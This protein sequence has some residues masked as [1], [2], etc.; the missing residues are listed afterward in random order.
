MR[1]RMTEA[2]LRPR[3]IVRLIALIAVFAI[4]LGAICGIFVLDARRAAWNQA[5]ESGKS[6]VA[7]IESD[8]SRTIAS[9]DLSLQAVVDNL[10]HPEI[11]QLSP[12]LRQLL[13]FDRSATAPHLDAIALLDENGIVRFESRTTHSKPLSRAERDYFQFHRSNDSRDL[14]ISQPFTARSNGTPLVAVSRRVSH[15]DGSFA[16][17]AVGSLKL[18]YFGELFKRASLGPQGHITLVR[19]DGIVLMR[20]P[21]DEKYIGMNLK[22]GEL[23]RHLEHARAGQFETVAKTDGVHR[24]VVYSQIGDF[25][26]VIGVGQSTADIFSR[27]NQYAAMLALLAAAL[28]VIAATLIYFHIVELRLRARSVA[29]LDSA[30][31]HM[32]QGLSMFDKD[33]KLVSC[34]DKYIEMFRLPPDLVEP[35]RSIREILQFR[36][37]DGTFVDDVDPYIDRLVSLL[38]RGEERHHTSTLID[39]RTVSIAICP[40]D[41]GGWVATY[42]DITDR[43][44]AEI[45]LA[46]VKTFLDTIIENVPVPVVVKDPESKRFLLVNRAYESFI[47]VPRAELIG[48]TVYNQFN[49][50]AASSITKHD[51]DALQRRDQVV[52]A[53]FP[54][55][56]WANG[57]R[58]IT[59]TRIVARDC[60]DRPLY[61]IV[62]IEDVTQRRASEAKIARLAHH[63]SLTDLANRV[64]FREKINESLARLRRYGTEFAVFLLD[65]DKFKAVNDTLGHQH[66]DAL[67]K[68]VANRIKASIREVD[69]AARLGGDEF[70]LVIQTGDDNLKVGA[71][72]L[73]K[74]LLEVISEPYDLDGHQVVIGGSIG[75]ALAPQ[76]SSDADEL[77]KYAD[78][79]MYNSKT[80]S[81]NDYRFFSPQMGVEAQARRTLELELRNA[82][83]HNQFELLY[84]PVIDLTTGDVVCAEAL[85]RWRHPQ[86]GLLKADEFMHCADEIGL[87]VPLGE[88]VLR[89]ACADAVSWPPGIKVAV[90]LSAVQCQK[91]DLVDIAIFVLAESGLPPKRLELEITERILLDRSAANISIF[92]QLQNIGVSIVLDDFGTG[93]SSLAYL[94]QFPF[95]KV[96]IHH[97]FVRDLMRNKNSAAIVCAINALARGLNIVTVADGVETQ[98]QCDVLRL[99]GCDQAQGFLFS[100]P[101]ASSELKFVQIAKPTQ[102]A[103]AA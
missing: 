52:S 88:W 39:G 1:R 35:G 26:L 57:R 78:L 55:E 41:G 13:L 72:Q 76:D 37:K 100:Q 8:I 9:Y 22:G 93:M 90:N 101:V 15:P 96:K 59:T 77:M 65:L 99:A 51:I 25:S 46:N 84:E 68:E 54:L 29:N 2:N 48:T 44:R 53:E 23:M 102:A 71:A 36:K 6:V 31:K 58:I 73:A 12:E 27:W 24:L 47:G 80:E 60:D 32:S 50:A 21:Y 91:S 61:L 89:Q 16:G 97:S 74:H 19:R 17:V 92:S 85:I 62:A 86:R 75:I 20:W 10:K 45:E 4:G 28:L 38:G 82:L 83:S 95:N 70:A 81:Q 103:S 40:R 33:L 7:A 30:L 5:A 14:Y 64:L 56:T 67:L 98:E 43:K 18:T 49:N 63:D 69:S 42:D 87:T 66:G 11:N 94:Q 3:S 34:N 79:A